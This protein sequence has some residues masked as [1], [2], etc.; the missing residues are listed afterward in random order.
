LGVRCVPPAMVALM[1]VSSSSSPRMA[2]CKWR[3]VIRFTRRSREAFPASSSTSA[4]RYSQMAAMYTAEVAPT[5]PWRATRFF[6]CLWIRPT[7]NC[8]HRAVPQGKFTLASQRFAAH[9]AAQ[10]WH[11]VAGKPG[12]SGTPGAPRGTI[13]TAGSASSCLMRYPF[14]PFLPFLPCL[15]PA[16]LGARVRHWPSPQGQHGSLRRCATLRMHTE[17][18]CDRSPAP[19]RDQMGTACR[20]WLEAI[21]RHR[22]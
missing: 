20:G 22:R 2:S 8:S 16:I 5:R 10:G 6:R 19:G 3:G 1:R 12:Q 4:Q 13:W 21:Q 7:G 11:Q 18:A 17:R 14:L 15:L 9:G